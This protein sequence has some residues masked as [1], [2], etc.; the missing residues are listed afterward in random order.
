MNH[1]TRLVNLFFTASV[2]L[3]SVNMERVGTIFHTLDTQTQC[4]ITADILDSN[5]TIQEKDRVMRLFLGRYQ[6]GTKRQLKN[7]AYLHENMPKVKKFACILSVLLE[8]KEFQTPLPVKP[9]YKF[10]NDGEHSASQ[11]TLR[12]KLYNK[13]D[14]SPAQ[15][16][17]F[18]YLFTQ[19]LVKFDKNTA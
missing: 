19:E 13:S 3:T 18:V 17:L 11:K 4:A 5:A 10:L 14:L 2:T 9:L 7:P 16:D 1:A 12:I 8:H 6:L 15:I